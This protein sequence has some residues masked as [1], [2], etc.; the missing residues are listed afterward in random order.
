MLPLA[1]PLPNRV[2]KK[3]LAHSWRRSIARIV[4][5]SESRLPVPNGPAELQ[6]VQF[7]REFAIEIRARFRIRANVSAEFAN[8]N[9]PAIII[10]PF[11]RA[12]ELRTKRS[13]AARIVLR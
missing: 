1:R 6:F 10:R 12:L 9:W 2:S 8:V 13:R 3:R 5:I 11:L 7:A 4:P